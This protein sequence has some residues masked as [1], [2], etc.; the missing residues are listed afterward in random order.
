LNATPAQVAYL[1]W[2]QVAAPDVYRRA[3]SQAGGL[4]GLGF[5]DM[6]VGAVGAVASLVGGSKAKKEAQKQKYVDAGVA[7]LQLL[8]TNTA[9][10]QQGLPPVNAQ[11]V[12]I[13]SAK[14]PPLAPPAPVWM[15]PA[16][17]GLGGLA[18]VLLLVRK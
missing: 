11:G 8:Q 4:R 9:R 1:R 12:V 17:L 13:P 7:K 5:I 15:M 10:V 2:L 18:V 16:L 6:I 14:L 3:Y